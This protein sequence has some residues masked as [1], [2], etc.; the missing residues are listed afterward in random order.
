MT[1]EHGSFIHPPIPGVHAPMGQRS[2]PLGGSSGRLIR[3]VHQ[4]RGHQAN[5]ANHQFLGAGLNQSGSLVAVMELFGGWA[6]DS[7][8]KGIPGSRCTG[9]ATSNV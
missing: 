5:A 7:G 8:V 6:T 2:C 4:P 3:L 1:V 9:M